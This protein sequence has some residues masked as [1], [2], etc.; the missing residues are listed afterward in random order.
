MELEFTRLAEERVRV[1]DGWILELVS[2]RLCASFVEE[3]VI[4]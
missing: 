1:I 3:D 2:G 4:F